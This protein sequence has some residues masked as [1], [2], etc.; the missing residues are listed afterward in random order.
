[1]ITHLPLSSHPS[2]EKVLVIGGGDGGVVREVLK[3]DMVKEV[4]LCDI[5]EVSLANSNNELW[6]LIY[7]LGSRSSV[8][9]IPPPYG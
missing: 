2:P 7:W 4:V 9:A 5:D 6:H 1:M 3:H 8:Q